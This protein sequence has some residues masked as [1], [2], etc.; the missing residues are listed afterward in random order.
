MCA[1]VFV[2][3]L[4]GGE[5][6]GSGAFLNLAVVIITKISNYQ[7]YI[8]RID[9]FS[10]HISLTLHGRFKSWQWKLRHRSGPVTG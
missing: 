8:L 2:C 9:K 7:R 10:Y 6:G 4:G 3:V 1:R 5:G